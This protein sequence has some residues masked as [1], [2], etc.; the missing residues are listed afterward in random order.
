LRGLV[1]RALDQDPR[2]RPSA[3]DLLEQLI[4]GAPG[5]TPVRPA[6]PALQ[7][8]AAAV[9]NTAAMPVT[10]VDPGVPVNRVPTRHALDRP[11]RRTLAAAAAVLIAAA[12]VFPVLRA[13]TTTSATGPAGSG[14]QADAG[15]GGAGSQAGAGTG[16]AGSGSQAD[17]ETSRAGDRASRAGRG[18]RCTLDGPLDLTGSQPAAFTCPASRVPGD[19]DLRAR[20][21]LTTPGGCAAIRI[22]VTDR[23]VYRVTVCAD[24]AT[25]DAEQSGHL[26]AIVMSALDPPANPAAWR[27]IEIRT[28]GPG[29]A[30]TLD[31]EAVLSRSRLTPPARG[32]VSLG[33]L[34]DPAHSAAAGRISYADVVI[35]SS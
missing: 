4:T 13:A 22:Q 7:R 6:R 8:A 9:R 28:S 5:S 20:L 19:R 30:V 3:H 18:D 21:A 2:R 23:T 25:L 35:A 33:S 27:S 32:A 11:R 31:G 26:R 14:S 24:H 15:T 10:P 12:G 16:G 34:P 1:R 17:A 29:I